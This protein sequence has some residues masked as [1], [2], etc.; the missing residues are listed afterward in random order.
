MD[1]RQNITIE[2]VIE[3]FQV[4]QGVSNDE[5][6]RKLEMRI[7]HELENSAPQPKRLVVPLYV[8]I[9]VVVA[10]T[11]IYMIFYLGFNSPPAYSPET[12]TQF[13]EVQQCWLPDSSSIELNSNSSIRYNYSKLTGHR[14]II[15][16][17]DALFKVKKGKDFI[18]SF[19]GGEVTVKGTSFYISAYTPNL[20]QVDCIEGAVDVALCSQTISLTKG[21][22]IKSFKGK[23]SERYL[24]NEQDVRNRLDGLYYWDK[25]SLAEIDEL[26][27]YRFGYNI[28]LE[29]GLES[30]NFSGQL[31]FT[32]INGCLLIISMAMNV[33][34]TIDEERKTISI[35]AN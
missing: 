3:S 35:N 2:Q 5:A 29:P 9:S 18:V 19:F 15:L 23:L 6:W 24:C 26:A 21:Q 11:V 32:N 8:T 14:N 28:L 13:G 27:E 7:H 1:D 20:L 16:K 33:I 10:A 34:Y 4:P 22:G 17:G 25:V 31:D 30:R 12:V